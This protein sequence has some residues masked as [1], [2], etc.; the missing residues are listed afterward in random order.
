MSGSTC[1]GC[2]EGGRAYCERCVEVIKAEA[3]SRGVASMRNATAD[4]FEGTID[5]AGLAKM[6]LWAKFIRELPD[7]KDEG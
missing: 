2:W 7:P 3:F 1:V 4:L 5:K 6:P